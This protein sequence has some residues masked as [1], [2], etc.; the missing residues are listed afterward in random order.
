M[1]IKTESLDGIASYLNTNHYTRF[2]I[3]KD[4]V[5][6]WTP[7]NLVIHLRKTKELK[8]AL[9]SLI[10]QVDSKGFEKFK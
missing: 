2:A 10:G 9:D 1:Y 3:E 8:E 4:S 7:D 6:A 5:E